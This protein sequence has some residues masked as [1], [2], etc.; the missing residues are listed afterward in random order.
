M[1]RFLNFFLES[2]Q[3]GSTFSILSCALTYAYLATVS[4]TYQFLSNLIPLFCLFFPINFKLWLTY[5]LWF[6]FGTLLPSFVP[7]VGPKIIYSP[8]NFLKILGYLFVNHFAIRGIIYRYFSHNFSNKILAVLSKFFC[9][10]IVTLTILA[11]NQSTKIS[12]RILHLFH[13]SASPEVSTVLEHQPSCWSIF[14][15]NCGIFLY[16]SP[17]GLYI[18]IRRHDFFL[19]LF[20]VLSFYFASAMMRLILIFFPA[21]AVITSLSIHTILKLARRSTS[22]FNRGLAFTIIGFFAIFHINS[23]V[24]FAFNTLSENYINYQIET[25]IGITRS[26]DHREAFRWLFE[27]TEIDSKV[28]AF[29]DIGY[30]LSTFSKR[31]VFIDGNTNNFTQ[32]SLIGLFAASK[33]QTAWKIARMLDADFFLVLFGGAVGFN[34]DD[35]S[36]FQWLTPA[37][38]RVF[39]NVSVEA[40]QND[41]TPFLVA[42]KMGSEVRK[43]MMFRAAY[44]RFGE[45]QGFEDVKKGWDLAREV[46]VGGLEFELNW[47]EESYT[48]LNWMIRIFRVKKDPQWDRV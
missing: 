27:N 16:L 14:F 38:H 10:V 19:L 24:Y 41:E 32:M 26:D 6:I 46:K 2:I 47:F 5:S 44:Y 37:I 18:L 12:A 42:E 22:L 33:E 39:E 45:Y 25:P 31:A 13:S 23:A 1:K 11:L 17:I 20:T 15:M 29:W 40:F 8:E 34:G 36:K 3:S 30:Q 28:I 21:F 43:S 35:V 9:V 7:F 4:G 48:S